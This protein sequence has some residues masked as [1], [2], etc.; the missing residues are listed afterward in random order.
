MKHFYPKSLPRRVLVSSL[1]LPLRFL[2]RKGSNNCVFRGCG[3]YIKTQHRSFRAITVIFLSLRCR[4]IR[5]ISFCFPVHVQGVV[6]SSVKNLNHCLVD[7]A[8]PLSH[9]AN[10]RGFWNKLIGWSGVFLSSINLCCVR[11]PIFLCQTRWNRLACRLF[12][13]HSSVSTVN[14]DTVSLTPSVVRSRLLELCLLGTFCLHVPGRSAP[15]I[16]ISLCHIAPGVH[17][18]TACSC[19]SHESTQFV[20]FS[21]YDWCNFSTIKL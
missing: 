1:F 12:R 16:A 14:S 8:Q 9:V 4:C 20:S 3:Q 13:A 18:S 5:C 2:I 11:I 19:S 7:L 15:S 6:N 10:Q 21:A 17:P